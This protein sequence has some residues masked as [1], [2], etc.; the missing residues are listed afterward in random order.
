[1]GHLT[2]VYIFGS[3]GRGEQDYRSDLDLLA[4]VSDGHGRV[5]DEEVLT[6]VPQHLRHFKP[7]ISWYGQKRLAEMFE[8][9]ELFAWHLYAETIPV[10][11][12]SAFLSSLGKPKPYKDA[13]LDV[14][15]FRRVLKGIPGHLNENRYNSIYETGLIY[16]CMR[17]IAMAAS[18][19]FCDKPDFTRY[20]PFRLRSVRECPISISEYETTMTCRMAAQRG[21]EPPAG[22]DADF[23]LRMYEVI[24]P[25]IECISLRLRQEDEV[26]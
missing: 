21:L 16:V 3:V 8:N 4:V 5:A 7:G 26:G 1:M 25:W 24:D 22:V 23:A 13:A 6:H 11:D 15:S 12:E 19:E 9:G 2:A 10:L 18:W 17:N 20:S 14:S